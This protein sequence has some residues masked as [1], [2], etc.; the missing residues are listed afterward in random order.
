MQKILV[1]AGSTRPNRKSGQ[2]AEWFL[3]AT[4]GNKDF[5]FELVDLLELDLPFFDEPMP[6]AMGNYQNAHTK[7]WTAKIDSADGYVLI[8]PE[9][10]HGYPAVLK[11]ALD[12]AYA[13]W[14]RKPVAFVSY[15]VM[16][17][18]RAVEQL[19][20]VAIQLNL[21]P[22]NAQ[23]DFNLFMHWAKDGAFT[24][25]ERTADRLNGMLSELKWWGET[26]KAGR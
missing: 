9:Y 24:P 6:P 8:T 23:V 22:L 7:E 18:V 13:E 25:D 1:I 11:N 26:L 16:N 4:Q 19:K 14:H 10:N 15:G 20:Q 3:N 2:V 21:A 5:E 12:F 17:G